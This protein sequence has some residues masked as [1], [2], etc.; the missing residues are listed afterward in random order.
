MR[1]KPL[2]RILVPLDLSLASD[3]QVMIASEL[4]LKYKSEIVLAH[5]IDSLV[6][7]HAA[8]GFDP[9]SLIASLEKRARDKLNEYKEELERRGVIVDVYDEFPVEDPAVAIVSIASRVGATEIL[10]LNKGWRVKRRILLGGTVK[11]VIKRSTKPVI[12]FHV[13]YDKKQ[14]KIR[15]V[16][17]AELTERILLAVDEN[18]NEDMVGY[19]RDLARYYETREL[20]LLHVMEEGESRDAVEKMLSRIQREFEGLVEEIHRVILA[21]HKVAKVIASFAE[22]TK[23]TIVLGRTVRKGFIEWVLGSTLDHVLVRATRP[24]VIY[25]VKRIE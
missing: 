20:Y 9:E 13:T 12:L 23:S 24:L 17:E 8:A 3:V 4:A 2:E 1:E 7:D 5:V 22:N 14:G 25:P 19:V 6:I 11:E 18:V 10:L 21:S 16:S 15:A